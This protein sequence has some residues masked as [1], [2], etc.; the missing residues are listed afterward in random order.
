MIKHLFKAFGILLALAAGTYFVLYAHRALAGKDLS[1][2]LDR[3]VMAAGACL[4]LLYASSILTTSLAWTR[5]LRA[6]KQ[7]AR[8]SRLLPIVATTQFG[9]YLPGNVAQHLGRIALA[10]RS[11]VALPAAV[12][13]VAYELLL[14]LVASAHIGAL[15]LLWSP[16]PAILKWRIT[17]Y[18]LPL[19]GAVTVFALGSLWLAPRIA[20]WLGRYRSGQASAAATAPAH[21]HL[22]PVSALVC[23]G[24]YASSYVLIGIGL[25]AVAH[26]LAGG[27]AAVPGILFFVGAFASS[28]ILGFVAPGAPAGLGIREAVLSAWLSGV[29]APANVVLLVVM[30]RIATTL[31]DLLNFAWGSLFVLRRATDQADK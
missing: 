17:E 18:R 3:N 25:W 8:L 21:L 20:V 1:A 28:W 29:L 9:K 11:G 22:D 15:T 5:L 6:L 23:Y 4:T 31:G 12:F 2:L 14:A 16:P 24:F 19:L 7:P 27:T 26:T 30:L 13:S 10:L